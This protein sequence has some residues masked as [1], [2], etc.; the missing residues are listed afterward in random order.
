MN[1]DV[2]VATAP[3][4]KKTLNHGRHG[5]HGTGNTEKSNSRAVAGLAW[6]SFH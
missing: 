3:E 1:S 4:V 2:K 6:H 5:T